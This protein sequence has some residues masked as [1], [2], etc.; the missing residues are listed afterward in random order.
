MSP[1]SSYL[2]LNHLRFHY[3]NWGG[4]GQ[5]LVLLH[6]LASNAHIWDL[7]APHL[8]EN[9]RVFALDQRN[10][11]LTDAAEDGFDFETITRDAYAFVEAMNLERP[12]LVGHSW[13]ASTVLAYAA[14]RAVGPFAPAA[15]VLVDGGLFA[16]KDVPGFTWEKAEVMLRPPE[17]DGMPVEDFLARMQ[18]FLPAGL[19]SEAVANIILANFRIDEAEKIY[20]RLPIPKHMQIARAI[21]EK[22]TFELFA[23]VRCPIL[24]CPASE[25][26]RDERGEQFLRLKQEGATR[27]AQTNPR[28]H[29]HWFENTIHDVPLQRPAELAEVVRH[30]VATEVH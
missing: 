8:A 23:R 29:T 11:G 24:L 20:R 4:N 15:I 26:P 13:G 19:Y 14:S 18:G 25:R 1:N 28:T 5:P 12:I 6:G 17:L 21:Y 10:H 30:F 16:M 9:F 2:L 27:A 3:L 22:Q 7:V